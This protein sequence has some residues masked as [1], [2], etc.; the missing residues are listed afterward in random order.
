MRIAEICRNLLHRVNML[1]TC[2]YFAASI[3]ERLT[4]GRW[5]PDAHIGVGKVILWKMA[6]LP[7]HTES[8][9]RLF[10]GGGQAARRHCQSDLYPSVCRV[11]GE[12]ESLKTS[13]D[14]EVA[15]C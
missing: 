8:T 6:T 14:G 5:A 13:Y 12:K 9:V 11:V 10:S 4:N 15:C 3:L 7:A 1:Q 2:L